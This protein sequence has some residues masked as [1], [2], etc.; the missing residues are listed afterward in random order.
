[1]VRA[2]VAGRRLVGLIVVVLAALAVAMPASA[3]ASWH[4]SPVNALPARHVRDAGAAGQRAGV[5]AHIEYGRKVG[6]AC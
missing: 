5:R 1:M 3:I 4:A 2:S 6:A